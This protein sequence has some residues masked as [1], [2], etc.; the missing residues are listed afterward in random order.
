MR[1]PATE[2]PQIKERARELTSV[3]R[4]STRRKGQYFWPDIFAS[5]IVYDCGDLSGLFYALGFIFLIVDLF[6]NI[7]LG[8]F[9]RSVL[10]D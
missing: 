6:G 4:A 2:K 3:I 1:E 10:E 8:Y 5:G 7:I 9:N